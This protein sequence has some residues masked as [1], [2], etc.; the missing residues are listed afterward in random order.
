M[1]YQS[2]PVFEYFN[3]SDRLTCLAG[4]DLVGKTFVKLAPST[5]PQVPAVVP[6]AAGDRPFGVA[7]CDKKKGEKVTVYRRGVVSVTAGAALTAGK[8]AAAGANGKAAAS[9]DNTGY[10]FVLADTANGDDAAVALAL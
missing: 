2:N 3:D 6:C 5:N 9:T 8:I 7:Q 1:A 10:G 4:E